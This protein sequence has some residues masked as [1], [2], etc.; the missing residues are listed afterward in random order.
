MLPLPKMEALSISLTTQS[1]LP[2]PEI[3]ATKM[4]TE[5]DSPLYS[6]RARPV[7]I[8]PPRSPVEAAYSSPDMLSD[9]LTEKQ[10]VAPADGRYYLDVYIIDAPSSSAYQYTLE[11]AIG[12]YAPNVA[13]RAFDL[14]RR[15]RR[16]GHSERRGQGLDRYVDD[17]SSC[18]AM[19][20]ELPLRD[21]HAQALEHDDQPKTGPSPSPRR[22]TAG[23]CSRSSAPRAQPNYGWGESSPRCR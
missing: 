2:L 17:G 13:L 10:F 7:S 23:R 20:R 21:L 9:P 11:Y 6:G 3:R 4:P 1:Q 14:H 8:P 15:L 18:R 22:S 19:G 16:H 12:D 5:V